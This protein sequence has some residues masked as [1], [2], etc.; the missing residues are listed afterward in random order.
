MK[1]LLAFA[2]LSLSSITFAE[3]CKET[4]YEVD[5]KTRIG[6]MYQESEKYF[7]EEFI[8]RIGSIRINSCYNPANVL[9]LDNLYYGDSYLELKFDVGASFFNPPFNPTTVVCLKDN[10]TAYHG[11]CEFVFFQKISNL[12][13]LPEYCLANQI[14]IGDVTYFQNTCFSN[15]R[16]I[17]N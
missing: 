1:I 4:K 9:F 15:I 17:E 8:N 13:I 10:T 16:K 3:D 11:K 14:D 7:D 2:L 5:I 6:K 12:V